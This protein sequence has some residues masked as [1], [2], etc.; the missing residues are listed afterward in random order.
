MLVI[1]LPSHL[2]AG[3]YFVKMT[4]GGRSISKPVSVIR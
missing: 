2:A 1:D 4:S 3:N